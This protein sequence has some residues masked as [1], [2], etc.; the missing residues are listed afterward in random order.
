MTNFEFFI[1]AAIVSLVITTALHSIAGEYYLIK[2]M[3][4]H[5]GNKVLN[6]HLAR[7]VIRFAWH[8]T[9]I[10]WLLLAVILYLTA[11]ETKDLEFGILLSTGV[12]FIVVGI[13]D[14]IVS[15][16]RHIGWPSLMAIGI[17]TFSAAFL[18]N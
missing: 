2:P 16:G 9:S 13:Y 4:K 3:F 17:C 10:L 5:R 1:I 15:R 18:L 11:F 6:H 12:V 14:L 7:I 8:L